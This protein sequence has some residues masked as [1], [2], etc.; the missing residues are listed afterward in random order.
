M[1]KPADTVKKAVVQRATGDRPG[2]LH[3]FGVAVIAGVATAALT[4][5]VLRSGGE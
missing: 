5:R 2:P 1:S 4:Y 3:A